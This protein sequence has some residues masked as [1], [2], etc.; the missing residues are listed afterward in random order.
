MDGRSKSLSIKC[1]PPDARCRTPDLTRRSSFAQYR[2]VGVSLHYINRRAQKRDFFGAVTIDVHRVFSMTRQHKNSR[3][4]LSWTSAGQPYPGSTGKHAYKPDR[5]KCPTPKANSHSSRLSMNAM[6]G[7][8]FYGLFFCSVPE[9][10]SR[11]TPCVFVVLGF[12]L[13]LV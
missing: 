13:A 10:L 3:S 6:I 9:S 11:V 2:C 12:R 8:S 7:G 1:S 4:G 5:L